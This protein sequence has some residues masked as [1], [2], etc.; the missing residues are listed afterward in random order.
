MVRCESVASGRSGCHCG[1]GVRGGE[2]ACC[3]QN[4]STSGCAPTLG[5]YWCSTREPLLFREER[6]PVPPPSSIGD[7]RTDLPREASAPAPRDPFFFLPKGP[8]SQWFDLVVGERLIPHAAGSETVRGCVGVADEYE[9]VAGQPDARDVAWCCRID[10][11]PLPAVAKVA[12]LV[13]GRLRLDCPSWGC[14]LGWAGRRAGAE[15]TG[16]VRFGRC[17][18]RTSMRL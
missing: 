8:V 18:T 9:S 13:A 10:A 4:G 17:T 3:G 12:G 1:G 15:R 2:A 5:T 14:S 7:V 11:V 16:D 6:L